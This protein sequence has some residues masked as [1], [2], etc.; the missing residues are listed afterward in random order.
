MK[1]KLV[2]IISLL[3]P[4]LPLQAVTNGSL[5]LKGIIAVINDLSISPYSKATNLD[6]VSGESG[7]V[8]A[9]VIEQSNNPDG[10]SIQVSSRNAGRLINTSST[11]EQ[12][13]YQISYNNGSYFTPNASAI[14]TK[15]VFSLSQKT[16]SVNS[17]KIKFS[18]LSNAESGS[19]EDI[20]TLS[21]VVK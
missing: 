17:L 21:I 4:L 3:S 18:G 6:I 20:M 11:N 13:F 10:Y 16:S 8:M 1:K 9:E 5:N 14:T 12:I 19:Y 7:T 2:F 15:A